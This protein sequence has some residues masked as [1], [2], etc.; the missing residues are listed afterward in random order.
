MPE[1]PAGTNEEGSVLPLTVVNVYTVCA[2]P[3]NC[4]CSAADKGELVPPLQPWTTL[5][6]RPVSLEH[7]HAILHWLNNDP[8]ELERLTAGGTGTK[9]YIG[10]KVVCRHLYLIIVCHHL[11]LTCL[12]NFV[13]FLQLTEVIIVLFRMALTRPWL[14]EWIEQNMPQLNRGALLEHGSGYGVVHHSDVVSMAVWDLKDLKEDEDFPIDGRSV[15]YV[16]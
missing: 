1:V 6:N 8:E 16:F 12:Y 15:R 9:A 11:H 2:H 7:L 10:E 14:R 3:S 13:I 5:A 4:E